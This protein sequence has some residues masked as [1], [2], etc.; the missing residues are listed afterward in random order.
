MALWRKG[1]PASFCLSRYAPQLC[2]T[3]RHAGNGN[4][5]LVSEGFIILGDVRVP[6]LVE[7]FM[8][9]CTA[10][11]VCPT[12]MNDHNSTCSLKPPV[13]HG[14]WLLTLSLVLLEVF[15]C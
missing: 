6:T 9:N 8:S 2:R 3:M 10:Y 15:T 14:R 4:I 5:S 1:S 7:L 13:S 12:K 11:L